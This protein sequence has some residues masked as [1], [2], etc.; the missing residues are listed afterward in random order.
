MHAGR[1]PLKKP[2]RHPAPQ[3]GAARCPSCNQL[4]ITCTWPDAHMLASCRGR[5]VACYDDLLHS[6]PWPSVDC[7][8]P[9]EAATSLR[10]CAVPCLPLA[11][12]GLCTRA[13][14]IAGRSPC[15]ARTPGLPARL[16]LGVRVVWPAVPSAAPQLARS[17]HGG[18]EADDLRLGELGAA[19][20]AER[21][22]LH[23]V[24]DA[25]KAVDVP[26]RAESNMQSMSHSGRGARGIQG[27]QQPKLQGAR[28]C[29][30]ASTRPGQPPPPPPDACCFVVYSGSLTRMVSMPGHPSSS[31]NT[32]GT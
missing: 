15:R 8:N 3:N 29:P 6:E 30:N 31:P 28:C 19:L 32:P 9:A 12:G 26:A 27:H 16:P 1:P 17:L 4:P 22:L 14:P 11:L 13:P 2:S 5:G 20:G 7:A 23:P 25:S 18:E 10:E 24:R 21:G